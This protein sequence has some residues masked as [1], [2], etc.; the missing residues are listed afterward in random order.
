MFFCPLLIRPRMASRNC[1]L[2][3]PKV[4]RPLRSRTVTPFTSREAIVSAMET[5]PC[6]AIR[7][8][9]LRLPKRPVRG[10]SWIFASRRQNFDQRQLGSGMQLSK[11][12]LIHEGS[13][14]EDAAPRAAQQVFWS[15][16]IGNGIQVKPL[17]L[18]GDGHHQRRAGV[19]K[20]GE[21]QLGGGVFI[22][23][24]NGVHGSLAR[25]S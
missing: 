3:S 10:A 9:F 18:I 17:A 8:T 5:P 16:R 20:A 19:L 14:E 4:I 7:I 15:Q 25:R 1:T 13:D 6:G 22:A 23:V 12:Y 21:D 2:P 24:E 11:V